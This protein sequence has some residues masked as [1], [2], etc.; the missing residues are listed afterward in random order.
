MSRLKRIFKWCPQPNRKILLNKNRLSSSILAGMLLVEITVLLIAPMGYYALLVPKPTYGAEQ[1]F[2][3]TNSQIAASWPNLPSADQIVK[4]GVYV[5]PGTSE[6]ISVKNCTVVNAISTLGLIPVVYQIFLR[7]NGT[8]IQVPYPD[9][10]T[11]HPPAIPTLQSG[12]LGTGLPTVYVII[13]V[14]AIVATF[15]MVTTYILLRRKSLDLKA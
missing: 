10:A 2:P 8:W 13:A 4:A 1:T 12:F 7:Y 5:T 6:M 14:I 3:L 11:N 9:L 15:V